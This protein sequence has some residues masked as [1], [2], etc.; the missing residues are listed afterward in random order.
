MNK[1]FKI[2][3][4]FILIF[5]VSACSYEPIFLKKNYD[6][7]IEEITLSGDKNVNSIIDSKLKFFG[8]NSENYNKIYLL[9]IY[10]DK[11]KR[12]IS[13][14]SKGNPL[15]FEISITTSYEV[16]DLDKTLINRIINKKNNYN[17]ESDKFKLEQSEKIIVEN[18]SER[19]VEEIIS[20]LINLNDS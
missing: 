15:K 16:M 5:V 10:T 3:K 9:N 12:I 14:D 6:F 7:K 19:I 20:S 2:L 13:K 1:F 8:N 11:R 17:N 4:F 18:L